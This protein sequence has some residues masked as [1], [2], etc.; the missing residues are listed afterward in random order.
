MRPNA[1]ESK[2]NLPKAQHLPYFAAT[3]KIIK[4]VTE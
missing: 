1:M 2:I 4:A 3:E